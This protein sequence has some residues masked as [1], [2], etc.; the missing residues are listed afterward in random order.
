MKQAEAQ[1]AE[2]TVAGESRRLSQ[3]TG[4]PCSRCGGQMYFSPKEQAL[5]CPYC[6]STAKILSEKVEAQ[7]YIYDPDTD[8]F[9][10]PDWNAAG[11][12]T[13]VCPS[14]GA[15]TLVP[16]AMMTA[17]CPFCGSHYV[18]DLENRDPV[19]PPETMIPFRLT[20][21]DV[22]EAFSRYTKKCIMAPFGFRKN[23]RSVTATGIYLPAFT[24]DTDLTTSYSGQ[25]GRVYTESYT[26]RVNGRTEHRTRR[27]VR[28]YPISGVNQE[29]LD[30]ILIPASRKVDRGL[31][32]KVA[33]FETKYLQEYNPAYLAGFFAERYDVGPE[34]CFGEAKA[35]AEASMEQKIKTDCGYDEYMSMR[36]QHNFRKVKFKHILLPVYFAAY[37]YG[38]KKLFFLVN[39]D[40]GRVA[41]H[42]PVSKLKVGFLV[43]L[44]L[45]VAAFIFWLLS[46]D[47]S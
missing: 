29:K 3:T 8:H 36:Y 42:I 43:L 17:D 6:Q 22:K 40:T 12:R 21:D 5:Y 46:G 14:C 18:A 13:L 44:G 34:Q 4:F 9:K 32:Q 45:A 37:R 25:G 10:A 11:N 7:E 2:G 20:V 38:Q 23:F 39:G 26:V 27:K 41:G 15:E 47:A 33:P 19:I 1:N 16:A 31:F 24:F 30:D 35:R 28:Y